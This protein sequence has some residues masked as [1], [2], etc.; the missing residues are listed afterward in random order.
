VPDGFER[1]RA[2]LKERPGCRWVERI[3]REHR[4]PARAA[5]AA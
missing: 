4:Q 2:P 3:Y 1:F 5:V